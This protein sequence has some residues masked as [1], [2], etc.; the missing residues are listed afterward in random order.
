MYYT[1][2]LPSRPLATVSGINQQQHSSS[3]RALRANQRGKVNSGID[4]N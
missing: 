2:I 4:L 3:Q 1:L